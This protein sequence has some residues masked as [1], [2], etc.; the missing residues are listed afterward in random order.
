MS[1][2]TN[3]ENYMHYA[4][5]LEEQFLHLK[6]STK[7]TSL[8]LLKKKHIVILRNVN[9]S[10]VCLTLWKKAPKLNYVA[11]FFM[12]IAWIFMEC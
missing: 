12:S 1:V 6:Q 11:L 8:D 4:H 5:F 7:S 3:A 9:F 2:P 10:V